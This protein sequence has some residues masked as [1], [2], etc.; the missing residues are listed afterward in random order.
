[1][2]PGSRGIRNALAPLLGGLLLASSV[3]V[4]LLDGGERATPALETE[5]HPATC[6]TG[7]DHTVCTQVGA[8]LWTAASDRPEP[9]HRP[10]IIVLSPGASPDLP[11]RHH[12]TPVRSRAP[13]FA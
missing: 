3:L 10:R 5:H 13:P 2:S 7:H 8:N 4:P 11:P 12:R 9:A 1:M 6:V